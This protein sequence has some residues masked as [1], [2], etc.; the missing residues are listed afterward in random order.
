M[1]SRGILAACTDQVVGWAL[2]NGLMFNPSKTD[3]LCVGTRAQLDKVRQ[4]TEFTNLAIAGQ[5]VQLGDR[6][7]SLGVTIDDQLSFDDHITD[8][9]RAV[10]FHTRALRRIRPFCTMNTAATLAVGIV[11]SLLDYCSTLLCGTSNA[12]MTKLQ[13]AQNNVAR[14]VLLANR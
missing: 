6:L 5:S 1:S 10:N 13:R 9:C 8:V 11:G 3:A 7:K 12:N 2:A 14:L 4:H